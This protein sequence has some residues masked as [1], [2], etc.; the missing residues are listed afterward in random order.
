MLDLANRFAKQQEEKKYDTLIEYAY[1]MLLQNQAHDSICGCSTED[2]HSENV[3]R[4]KKIK[5]VANTIIDEL[6]FKNHFEEKKIINLSDKSFSGIVEFSTAEKLEGYVKIGYQKGFE[7]TLLTDTQRIP[8]TEDYTGINTYLAEVED[9]KPNVVDYIMPVSKPSD[10]NITEY[11][12][13]NSYLFLKIENGTIY[14]NGIKMSLVDF[15][16]LGDSYNFGPKSDDKGNEL[17]ILRSKV[18]LKTHLRAAL[19]VDFESV[20][21][22]VSAT[23]SLDRAS[24]SLSFKFDWVNSQKNHILN[25][26][27]ELNQP[28]QEVFSED[29]NILIKRNFD[30]DYNIRENLPK[31]RG[32]EVKNNTAPMQR[33]L[34]I[35]E[36]NNNIGIVTKG[37]TQ[38]EVYK[39]TL[40]IPILRSTGI[41]SNP[42]NPARTTPAG[43]PIPVESLQQIGRN[44]AEFHVFFGNQNAF[45]ETLNKVYSNVVT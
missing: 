37:L 28:I 39:N 34:L 41:I 14:I 32:V 10:L 26:V 19:K 31:I 11:S 22:V 6:K 43:P 42:Q 30:A 36:E 2:V 7:K 12:L 15:A 38:Y 23:I 29:M 4:Y 17:K 9:V 21:D 33:G 3:I 27:F 25:A 5:Q 1:K 40:M 24:T 20:W 35:D 45:E 8:V 44:I 13:E 16:D 18:V